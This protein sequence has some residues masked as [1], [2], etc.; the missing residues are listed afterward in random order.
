MPALKV[1][2]QEIALLGDEYF[3][4]DSG[5]HWRAAHLLRWLQQNFPADLELRTQFVRHDYTGE[6]AVYEI[7]NDGELVS[8]IPLYWV[9]RRAPTT[10]PFETRPSPEDQLP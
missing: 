7:D 3:L 5:Y 1:I 10:P 2:L 6:G 4:N 9:D 8:S